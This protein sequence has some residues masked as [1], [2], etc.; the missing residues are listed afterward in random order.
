MYF[1]TAQTRRRADVLL[2]GY[3]DAQRVSAVV[4]SATAVG[5]NVVYPWFRRTFGPPD[6]VVGR[7]L[8][9]SDPAATCGR[10][11]VKTGYLRP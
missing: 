3:V 6:H 4:Y 11:T 10:S 9:W 1:P 7:I 8:V 5:S 2:C